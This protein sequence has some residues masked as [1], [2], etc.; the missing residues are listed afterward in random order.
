MITTSVEV[1]YLGVELD[2][3][4]SLKPHIKMVPKKA[5]MAL[6]RLRSLYQSKSKMSIFPLLTSFG[7]NMPKIKHSG[8]IPK[9]IENHIS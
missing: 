2:N 6:A 3:K 7:M 4:L 1:R 8:V 5:S 9:Q